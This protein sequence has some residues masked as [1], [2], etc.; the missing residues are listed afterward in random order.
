[1]REEILSLHGE[2]SVSE[3]YLLIAMDK[4]D[5]LIARSCGDKKESDEIFE[6]NRLFFG[7]LPVPNNHRLK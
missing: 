3:F 4:S 5:M 2:N 1:M 6:N 7:C